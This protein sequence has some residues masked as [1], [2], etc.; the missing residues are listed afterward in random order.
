MKETSASC[1]HRL[2][3]AR[4]LHANGCSFLQRRIC[5]QRGGSSPAEVG[6][7]GWRLLRRVRVLAVC[8]VGRASASSGHPPPATP[9]LMTARVVRE[10]FET[11]SIPAVRIGTI[12]AR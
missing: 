8:R 2:G 1:Q 4:L 10:P 3:K 11:C 6:R 5:D 9:H 7:N 12:R